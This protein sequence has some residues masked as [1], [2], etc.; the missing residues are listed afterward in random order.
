MISFKEQSPAEK[1]NKYS[2]NPSKAKN[3]FPKNARISNENLHFF[4]AFYSLFY[5]RDGF[6]GSY[7]IWAEKDPTRK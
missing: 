5:V 1:Q 3:K 6:W 7:G 2:H 4:V